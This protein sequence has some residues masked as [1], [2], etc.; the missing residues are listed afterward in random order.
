MARPRRTEKDDPEPPPPHG[1]LLDEV[2]AFSAS[3]ADFDRFAGGLDVSDWLDSRSLR[4]GQSAVRR[5]V[6]AHAEVAD[7]RHYFADR[8]LFD[9]E[10]SSGS[11]LL[12]NALW[13]IATTLLDGER[14]GQ[15]DLDSALRLAFGRDTISRVFGAAL[16]GRLSELL[17]SLDG[18]DD[19]P[20]VPDVDRIPFETLR[21]IGCY[22]G[23]RDALD[24]VARAAAE[25]GR[26]KPYPGMAIVRL[27]PATGCAPDPII[28]VGRGFGNSRP[29]DAIVVFGSSRAEVVRGSWSDTRFAVKIPSG[30]GECCVSVLQTPQQASS[31]GETL[32][33]AVSNL[34]GVVTECFGT[35]GIALG[36]KLE[37]LA[38]RAPDSEE[39]ECAPDRSNRFIGGPPRIGYFRTSVGTTTP[40]RLPPGRAWSSSGRSSTHDRPRS[41][42]RLDREHRRSR[43][44]RC[45]RRGSSRTPPTAAQ[46]C[47]RRRVS[48]PGRWTSSSEQ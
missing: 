41:E 10:A 26:T 47:R 9:P 5:L 23:L 14:A 39:A 31:A 38:N 29:N 25:I 43:S 33:S 15:I 12:A 1:S 8:R 17:S 18:F 11:P 24:G 20:D 32:T 22:V 21:E 6:E 36:V 3:V 42:S 45:S 48:S 4:R 40:Q 13:S 46:S 44:R 30:V 19:F 2:S 37:R 34:A 28:V 7:H 35:V 27:E 16:G